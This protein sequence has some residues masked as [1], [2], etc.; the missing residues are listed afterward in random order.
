MPEV[1]LVTALLFSA[2]LFSV[3]L[4]GAISRKAAVSILMSL[5]IMLFA[6]TL[7]LVALARFVPGAQPHAW[8]F[9]IFIMVLGAAEIAIGL[10]LV[11]ALYRRARTSKV[12]DLRE[13]KG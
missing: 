9:I 5:E 13:L 2:T 12:E 3:G 11:V 10:S 6:I 8:F 7:N 4:Y 1:G